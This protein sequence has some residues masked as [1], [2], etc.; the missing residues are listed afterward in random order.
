MSPSVR[1][2]T[3][4]A[5]TL[6]V[7]GAVGAWPTWSAGGAAGLQAMGL[8][9]L[10]AFAGAVAGFLPLAQAADAPMERKANAAL[11]GVLV[12]LLAT[13]GAVGIMVALGVVADRSTFLLWTAIDYAALLAVEVRLAISLARAG[14]AASA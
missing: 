8:A 9:A 1:F 5:L 13:G 3:A 11:A 2:G 14:G 10:A 12:R 6:L 4:A 7:V